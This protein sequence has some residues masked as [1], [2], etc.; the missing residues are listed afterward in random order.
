MSNRLSSLLAACLFALPLLAACAG[1]GQP[2]SEDESALRHV[3][4]HVS[5]PHWLGGEAKAGPYHG[6][7]DKTVEAGRPAVLWGDTSLGADCTPVGDTQLEVTTPPA[8]GKT[9]IRDGTLYAMYPQGSDRAYCSG[10]L[11][12]GVLAVYTAESG[13]VGVDQVVLRGTTA[14]GEVREVTVNITVTPAAPQ[15][16]RPVVRKATAATPPAAAPVP[17][18]IL[19]RPKPRPVPTDPDAPVPTAPQ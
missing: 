8:H 3:I 19:P 2:P 12:T 6:S 9:V 1:G 13:Y 4:P 17:P 7:L 15:R 5:L 18:P 14:Q 11:V 10:R 16:P